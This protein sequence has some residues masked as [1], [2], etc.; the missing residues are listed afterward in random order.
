MAFTFA[1]F[2]YKRTAHV[3]VDFIQSSSA[4]A[5]ATSFA[6]SKAY[7]VSTV[8]SPTC[9]LAVNGSGEV[10]HGKVYITRL[11]VS[12]FHRLGIQL[13]AYLYLCRYSPGAG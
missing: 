1:F 13:L 10:Q 8:P 2:Y 11:E 3:V 5:A 9:G 12:T 6:R 4:R 7:P